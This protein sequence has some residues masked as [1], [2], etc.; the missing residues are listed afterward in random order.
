[1][2]YDKHAVHVLDETSNVLLKGWREPTGSRL[3]RFSLRSGRHQLSP[4]NSPPAP[5]PPPPTLAANNAYDMPSVKALV[6]FLHAAAGFPVKSTWLAAIKAGNYA[7]WPGLTYDNTNIYH[8]T[9]GETLKDHIA[10]TRQGVRSTNHKSTSSKP[11]R[12]VSPLSNNVPA[13][14]SNELYVVIEP[15]SNLYTDDMGR[16][17]IRSRSG[18]R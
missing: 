12:S 15:V 1:M 9:T 10:H 6:R 7:T 11:T 4:D 8:P 17:P 18:H 13:K 16:F 14:T 3:W 5:A 2:I